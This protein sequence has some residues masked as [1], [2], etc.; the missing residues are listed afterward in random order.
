MVFIHHE[1][2]T[3]KDEDRPG[4]ESYSGSR[5][6]SNDCEVG[7]WLEELKQAKFPLKL[8]IARNKIGEKGIAGRFHLAD[9]YL[10][11]IEAGPDLLKNLVNEYDGAELVEQVRAHFHCSRATAFRRIA[12]ARGKAL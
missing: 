9:G 1:R 8:E 11:T 5:A 4:A 12:E 2:K 7:L 3:A 6:W 10:L